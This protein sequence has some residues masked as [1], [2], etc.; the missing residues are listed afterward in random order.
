MF[1]PSWANRVLDP[2]FIGLVDERDLGML[3]S[4]ELAVLDISWYIIVVCN[5][6]WY[7]LGLNRVFVLCHMYRVLCEWPMY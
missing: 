2:I 5:E 4:R 7:A 6:Q 3:G 1:F